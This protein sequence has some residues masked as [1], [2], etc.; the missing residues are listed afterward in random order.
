M[1]R[2]RRC[3]AAAILALALAPAAL[4]A[5]IDQLP[6]PLA[7][8]K[9]GQWLEHRHNTAF[10]SAEQKQRI[11]AV[12]G[13]GDDKVI[14]AESV[15]TMDGEV[16]DER[17]ESITYGAATEQQRDSLKDAEGLVI[18]PVAIEVKDTTVDGVRVDFV[19]DETRFSLY[20]SDSIP[21]TGV[22]RMEVEGMEEPVLELLDYGE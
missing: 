20:L 4:A 16:V 7:N 10:G 15:M 17:E 18:T 21:I 3:L 6:N 22:V 19:Q 2:F 12:V 14:T 5:D 1:S 13:E 11:T 8:V 9:V